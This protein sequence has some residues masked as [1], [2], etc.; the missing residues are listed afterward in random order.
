MTGNV[1]AMRGTADAK[2]ADDDAPP[3]APVVTLG[4]SLDAVDRAILGCL[5]TDG[6]MTN[7]AIG[8]SVGVTEATVRRRLQRMQD[9]GTLRVVPVV[10]PN[11]IGLNTGL[12]VGLKVTPGH[13]A[14]VSEAIA[15]LPEVRYVAVTAGQYDMLVEAFVGGTSDLASLILDAI[16]RTPHVVSIET[17]TVL[18]VAKFA[19]EWEIPSRE[20]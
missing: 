13:T 17:M 20:G 11:T 9:S 14:E 1:R 5:R 3:F 16:G 18:R 12:F 10:E 4:I 6:R 2:G 7:K 19:Y 8:H 15:K